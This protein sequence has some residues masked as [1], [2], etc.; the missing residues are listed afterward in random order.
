MTGVPAQTTPQIPPQSIRSESLNRFQQR[1]LRIHPGGFQPDEYLLRWCPPLLADLLEEHAV[2]LKP[3]RIVYVEGEYGPLECH[4]NALAY[5]TQHPSASPWYGFSLYGNNRKGHGW[6]IHSV[7]LDQ[8]GTL[9][10]PAPPA[11]PAHFLGIPWGIELFRLLAQQ[12]VAP[13]ALPPV[14]SRSIFSVLQ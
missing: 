3:Q 5:G 6:W 9:I 7:C 14:L 11:S 12:P 2:E 8:D 4:R 1:L 13:D 10:D